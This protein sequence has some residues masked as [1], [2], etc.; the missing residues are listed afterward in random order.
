MAKKILSSDAGKPR[1]KSKPKIKMASLS[2]AILDGKM[3]VPVGGKVYF[4][5]L[6][7]SGRIEIHEGIIRD[8]TDNGL[9]EIWD[10][11]IE[12]FYA[13]SLKQNLPVIKF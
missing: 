12:Q 6:V 9:V 5:R 11:T 7:S 3:I 13:F 1:K 4:E 10:E 2:D 8:I